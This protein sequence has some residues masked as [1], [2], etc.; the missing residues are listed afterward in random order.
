[1]NNKTR[2]TRLTVILST[3][4]MLFLTPVGYAVGFEF[5]E[6][7]SIPTHGATD[8]EFFTIGSDHYLALANLPT[9]TIPIGSSL[10]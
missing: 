1:M 6:F 2:R 8:W 3:A 5:E 7:Q 4:L 9:M 10:G